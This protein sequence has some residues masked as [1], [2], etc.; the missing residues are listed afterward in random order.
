MRGTF[1]PLYTK[2][3]LSL[4]FFWTAKTSTVENQLVFL[5]RKELDTFARRN[6][7]LFNVF[8]LLETSP[9]DWAY[10]KG[11]CTQDLIEEKL[12]SASTDTKMML[13]GPPGMVNAAN[14]AMVNL[15]FEKPG[16]MPKMTDEIFLF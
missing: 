15:R 10:G 8:Y 4:S 13:C 7:K 6:S 5:L 9:E 2:S 1:I 11:Y 12:P 3:V 16:A 14:N